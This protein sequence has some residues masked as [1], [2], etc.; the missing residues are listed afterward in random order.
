M[1]PQ[2][3]WKPCSAPGCNRLMEPRQLETPADYARRKYCGRTCM[4]KAYAARGQQPVELRTCQ[5]PGCG[6]L[7]ERHPGEKPHQYK[8]R[9]FC[10]MSCSGLAG[11]L[12]RWPNGRDRKIPKPKPEPVIALTAADEASAIEAFI[13]SRGVTRCPPKYVA[14]TEHGAL[15]GTEA[16]RAI[17]R[18]KMTDDADWKTRSAACFAV[19]HRTGGHD[20]EPLIA[21]GHADG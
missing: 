12:A 4:A 1:I 3:D 6:K 10:C 17:T 8:L 13:A 18:V 16:Q 20:T 9:K 15:Y 14:P 11:A 2:S 7:I 19:P 5:R 21:E